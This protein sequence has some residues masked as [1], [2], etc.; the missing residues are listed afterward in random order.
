MKT[1][2]PQEVQFDLSDGIELHA[3]VWGPEDG[4]PIVCTHGWVFFI[5]FLQ[6]WTIVLLGI[7]LH[8]IL[9]I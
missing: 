4:F 8:H 2:I 5:Y 6:R 9:V 3:R 7:Q 1:E